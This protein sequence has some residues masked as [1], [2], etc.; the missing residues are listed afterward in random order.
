[1]N[2]LV[3]KYMKE[4]YKMFNECFNKMDEAIIQSDIDGF[5]SGNTTIQKAM[6]RQQQ[7]SDFDEFNDFMLSNN[8]LKL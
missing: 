6:G 4:N 3:D 2:A 8:S 1:M 5:I 7:F